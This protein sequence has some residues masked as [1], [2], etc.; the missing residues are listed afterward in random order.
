MLKVAAAKNIYEKL[1]EVDLMKT[2]P[3]E[4]EVF[5]I[6]SCV[7]VTTYLTPSALNEWLRVVKP[8]GLLVFTTKTGVMK[9]WEEEQGKREDMKQWE[10][11]YKSPPLYYLPTL[12]DPSKERVYVF[13]YR[14]I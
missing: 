9:T 3:A 11:V 5:D 13:V 2:L 10:R 6:L 1:H 12:T 8:A 7:G 14:K 4:S